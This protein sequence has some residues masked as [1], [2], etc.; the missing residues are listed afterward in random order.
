MLQIKP[1]RLLSSRITDAYKINACYFHSTTVIQN[2]NKAQ[3]KVRAKKDNVAGETH[4]HAQSIFW[5]RKCP[6]HFTVLTQF[7]LSLFLPLTPILG[8]TLPVFEHY[9]EGGDSEFLFTDKDLLRL[10][11]VNDCYIMYLFLCLTHWY[12]NNFESTSLNRRFVCVRQ[13]MSSLVWPGEE[14]RSPG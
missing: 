13:V 10:M 14:S 7:L 12:W 6:Y 2:V 4:A 9:Q 11:S 8:V 1:E 3:V 5:N